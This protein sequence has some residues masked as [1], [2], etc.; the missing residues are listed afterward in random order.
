M[1]ATQLVNLKRWWQPRYTILLIMWL[2]YGCFYLNRLALGPVIPLIIEDL[3]FSHTQVGLISSFLFAFYAFAQF[4]AGYLSDIFGPKKIITIGGLTSALANLLFSTGSSLFYLIGFQS[5]NGAGQGGAFGPI[6]K[7]INNWFPK[8][9]RGRALGIHNTCVSVFSLL[10]YV[11]AGYLGKT[12]GWR[13]VFWAAPIILLPVLFISWMIVEDNPPNNTEIKVEYRLKKTTEKSYRNLDR[14]KVILTNKN[15]ILACFAFFC[16]MYITYCNLIWLPAYLYESY[17]LS[18]IKTVFL[19]GVY[20][21]VGLVA[22]PLGGFLSDVPLEGRRKPLL[23]VGFFF[24]LLATFFLANTAYLKWAMALIVIVGFFDQLIQ[25]LFFALELDM[26]PSELAGTGAGFLEAGGHLGSMSAMLF[27]GLLVDLFG[28]YKA[29]FL[30]LSFLA[31][32]GFVV[33]IFI[34]ED[35]A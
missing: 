11:L 28:T 15:M 22:R 6:V 9:E 8:S 29:V 27:T 12:F 18:I 3:N 14:L 23:L 4:P 21:A 31:V 25:S 35:K 30:S 10:A 33:A 5:L 34:R 1:N 13:A 19:A 16:L 7:L 32:T 17:E 24:I 26:L 2:V 20:P